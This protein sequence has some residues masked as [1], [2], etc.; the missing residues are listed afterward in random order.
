MTLVDEEALVDPVEF[1]SVTWDNPSRSQSEESRA[2]V[3]M[4]SSS[5]SSY[6][7][8]IGNHHLTW[9]S[10]P[11]GVNLPP[12]T[13]RV[14]WSKVF[15]CRARW[16]ASTAKA[17]FFFPSNRFSDKRV[18]RSLSIISSQFSSPFAIISRTHD[19]I[20]S[21]SSPLKSSLEPE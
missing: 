2:S 17:T 14:V 10:S 15:S 1:D 9:V 19:L 11:T 13:R 18:G 12:M 7:P 8:R 20:K 4:L 3:W 21:T 16:K 5:F 6:P